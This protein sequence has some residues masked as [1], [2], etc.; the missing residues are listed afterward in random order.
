[1]T[2]ALLFAALTTPLGTA[3][4][5]PFVDVLASTTL[6]LLLS[7]SAGMLLFVGATHLIPEAVRA[8][9][10]RATT[11]AGAGAFVILAVTLVEG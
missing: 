2:L 4:S 10:W 9:G 8:S 5:Y 11:A 3:I 1:V 6:G 7:V